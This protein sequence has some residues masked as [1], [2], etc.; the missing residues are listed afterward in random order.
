MINRLILKSVIEKQ[1]LFCLNIFSRRAEA[2][3]RYIRV[4]INILA[5]KVYFLGNVIGMQV[6]PSLLS[7]ML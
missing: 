2:N 7:M 1:N 3:C 4:L 5:N 6:N